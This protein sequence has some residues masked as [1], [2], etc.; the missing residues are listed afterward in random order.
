MGERMEEYCE[1]ICGTTEPRERTS[2]PVERART[3]L[4]AERSA[5][6]PE[7]RLAVL[8]VNGSG[9]LGQ[10]LDDFGSSAGKGLG[11]DGGV[12]A[13]RKQ[14]LRRAEKGSRQHDHGSGSISCLDILCC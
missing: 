10:I 12:D 4:G 14:L 5:R 3:H 6:G 11:N 7:E 2:P 9:H 1:T 13:F 8:E